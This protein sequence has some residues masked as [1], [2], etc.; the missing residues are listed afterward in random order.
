M[1]DT[2]TFEHLDRLWLL[3]A[4]AALVVWAVVQHVGRA[5]VLAKLGEGPVV[6][7]LVA[8][9]VPRRAALRIALWGTA[10]ALLVLASARPRYGLRETEVSNA[11]ID[12]ALV[13][14]ASKSMLVKDVLPNRLQGTALEIRALLERLAGG[15]VALVPFAGIPFVQC[16]LTTDRDVVLTYLGD[17]KPEDIPV[18]GT[19]IGR[20]IALAVDTLT[21]EKERQDAEQKDNLVPQFKGSKHKAIVLFTDGEDHEGAAIEAAQKAAAQGIRIYTVGVGSALGNPVPVLGSDG[22]ATGVL[23]DEAG[24]PIFSKLNMPLLEQIA[25]TTGGKAFQYAGK[26]VVP[27]LFLALDQ[28]EKAEYTAQF[29]Q[30]GED[31]YQ[32]LLGPALLLLLLDAAL[33]N[34][35][36]RVQAR[37]TP[38]GKP[39]L[40]PKG[41]TATVLAILLLA[42]G[43]LA[44]VP[45]ARAVP[46]WLQHENGDV[47]EGRE[48]LGEKQ[49]GEALKAFQQAQASRPEH[50][51]L[52]YDLALAQAALGAW[53]DAVTSLA[54]ALGGL[55]E[56]DAGLEADIHFA[57]G[58]T[59]L[60]WAR[61]I[62]AA[63]LAK[64][65]EAPKADAGK[66]QPDKN[67]AQPG[68]PAG[69][70]EPKAAVAEDPLAHY[71]AAVTSLEQALLA[72]P[73]RVA[74]R[75][76]L[77]I[78]R[79]GAF[80]PCRNRDKKDEPNDQPGQ[81]TPVKF[82]DGQHEQTLEERACPEDRDMFRVDL[83]PGDRFSAKVATKADPNPVADPDGG[84]G[85]P[86]RLGLRLLGADGKEQIRGPA[87]D[88]PPLDA[89]DLGKV[90]KQQTVL[91]DVRNIAE[92]ETPYDLTFKLLPGCARIEDK[93]E[94]ND[95]PQQARAIPIGQPVKG[96][97]CPLN[98]DNFAVMLQPEQGLVVHLKPKVDIGSDKVELE[99][100]DPTG[101]VVA[102]GRSGKDGMTARMAYAAEAGAYVVQVRGGLD[103]EADYDLAL[104]V[105][106]PC[107]E[108]D[109]R[110]ED[111]DQAVQANPLDASMIEKPL[112]QLQL[113]PAD[114]DWYAVE[115]KEGESLF[116]DLQAQVED[117]PDVQ[118]LAGSLTVE[119]YDERGVNWGKAV[120]GPV[121]QGG[122]VVRTVAVLA[123]P[124][125]KYRVRVTGGGV[126]A[127]EFPLPMLPAGSVQLSAPAPDPNAQVAP[128]GPA[129]PQMPQPGRGITATPRPGSLPPGLM[130]Q[131]GQMPQPG[132]APGQPPPPSAPVPHVVLPPG[133]AQPAVDHSLAKLDMPYTLKLRIL[134]PCPAGNDELEPNDS[135]GA[136]K[137]FEVGQEQL[138]RICKGDQDW[139]QISQKAGQNLQISARYDLSHGPVAMEVFD[140]AG[141][142]SIVQGERRG[143]ENAKAF[144]GDDTP[145]A[146]KGRTALTAAG[147]PA[148]KTDRVV[149]VRLSADKDVEN[150]YVLRV[151][152]PPPPSDKGQDKKDEGDKK[153]D[154]KDD[155]GKPDD[156]KDE[157]KKPE[158]KPDAQ[159]RERL[160]QQMQRNDHDPQNLEALEAMRRSQFRNESPAKDW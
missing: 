34:R 147:I 94:P 74:T 58:T 87:Q 90:D 128:P 82:E 140:E 44:G 52:W 79:L 43:M 70:G 93:F 28:L 68:K 146:R 144:S 20:A 33:T 142:K 75:R 37:G 121:S 150:F 122:A 53:Q 51:V 152:E 92:V 1:T 99:V 49:F 39:K 91:V 4:V 84:N 30:L 124:P 69:E 32:V 26:S 36:R 14:D 54:R 104:E 154:K 125:G 123:P 131:P 13:V 155:K 78:A 134:P 132:M 110:Y 73:T 138:M 2:L 98:D 103:T 117:L 81:A 101:K 27:Q 15:R 106:P 80:P 45:D 145:E 133:F 59:Q 119:V 60:Q 148:S 35:R 12:V 120:G 46:A 41:K 55:R 114:D 11:G 8:S 66:P 9:Y 149:K 89:V 76:N 18:G 129:L 88:G 113:C 72:D 47:R 6:R 105:L 95:T 159:E 126:A 61:A 151:E 100:L 130:P 141:T 153:D 118:D 111:N 108:R 102:Q 23:K 83:L 86:P 31:R 63:A 157:G 115:L 19:N 96:R 139:L 77:E 7:R 48:K 29:Q 57:T 24:M 17:L 22:A 3:L 71:R 56:H 112:D 21:G 97:L 127:P 50:V 67:P 16:P 38:N 40:A 116:V 137:P 5:R 10:L 156:K 85:A 136:A 109:D 158:P 62:E 65:A 64:K 25:T 135:A 107:R 143:A 42:V 160:K